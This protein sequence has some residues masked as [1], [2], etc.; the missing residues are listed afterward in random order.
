MNK[1]GVNNVASLRSKK[2]IEKHKLYGS[3][4]FAYIA[5]R[6]CFL[7][8]IIVLRDVQIEATKKIMEAGQVL[9]ALNKT[10]GEITS[11]FRTGQFY[12]HDNDYFDIEQK[13]ADRSH[14]NIPLKEKKKE[15]KNIERNA[16]KK[17]NAKLLE[18]K[19][20]ETKMYKK[21][22]NKRIK[23]LSNIE[24]VNQDFQFYTKE[25]G[26]RV[27]ISKAFYAITREIF[28]ILR[29]FRKIAKNKEDAQQK[30][31]QGMKTI[32]SLHEKLY[33]LS[34]SIDRHLHQKLSASFKP[35]PVKQEA[36]QK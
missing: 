14:Y 34:M 29:S 13:F 20:I 22:I 18:F 3:S 9:K 7:N 2:Y 36:I 27:E 1:L 10:C 21:K 23:A 12:S 11:F 33:T 17:V 30:L 24:K 8:Y 35:A 4:F 19:N 31:K 32:Q 26:L 25:Y 15:V 5:L 6:H 16:L 28:D